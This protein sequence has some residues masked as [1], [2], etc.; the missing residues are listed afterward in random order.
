[1]LE[2]QAADQVADDDVARY[3]VVRIA[4]EIVVNLM[5]RACGIDYE[6]AAADAERVAVGDIEIPVAS[7]AT[8]I[9]TK[10]TVRP[11]DAVDRRYLE[12]LVRSKDQG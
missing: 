10:N 4:D 12:E 1:M 6:E 5:A 2:D 9:R 11:S 8:L 7:R 3:T